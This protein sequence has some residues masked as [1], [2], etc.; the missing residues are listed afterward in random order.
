MPQ[1]RA[2]LN[3]K[4]QEGEIGGF[5]WLAVKELLIYRWSGLQQACHIE[6]QRPQSGKW[7]WTKCS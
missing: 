2:V 4:V 3:L 6:S 1:V 7:A 5:P